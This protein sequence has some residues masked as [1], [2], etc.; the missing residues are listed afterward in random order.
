MLV[1]EPTEI[2]YYGSIV[3]APPVGE[4]FA[5]IFDYKQI[6]P[7]RVDES[8]ESFVMPNLIGLTE[9]ECYNVLT[10]MG[11]VYEVAGDEGVVL[12]T[13]PIAGTTIT[14]KEVVLLRLQNSE[15]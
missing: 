3:A 15:F 5:K 10:S 11:I 1:D 14:D 6:P 7:T 2:A 4:V 9:T 13:L 8:S 12:S